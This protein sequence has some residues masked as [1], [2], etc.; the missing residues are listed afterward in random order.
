LTAVSLRLF[1][2]FRKRRVAGFLPELIQ[3]LGPQK[4]DVILDVGAGTGVIAE[5]ISKFCDEV[6][7]LEPNPERVEFIKKR[8]PQVKAFDGSAEAIQFPESYFTKI[9]AVSSFHHFKDKETAL[10][11]LYRVLKRNGL[12]VIKDS[13]PDSMVSKMETETSSVNFLTSDELKVKLEQIGF[14]VKEV[15]KSGSGSFFLSS[16]KV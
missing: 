5:E 11:E 1:A 8:Y 6:F 16:A 3:L 10:Y 9:Y 14:E 15:R 7:A 2:W 13:E 4:D 12:L